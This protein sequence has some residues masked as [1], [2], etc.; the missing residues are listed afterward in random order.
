MYLHSNNLSKIDGNILNGLS[1]LTELHLS[2]NKLSYLDYKIFNGLSS[3]TEL[4]LHNNN[5]FSLEDYLFNGLTSLTKLELNYNKFNTSSY[6]SLKIAINSMTNKET[7]YINLQ[8]NLI[9]QSISDKQ[10]LCKNSSVCK[11]L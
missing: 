10:V 9:L 4:Y 2:W 3:L 6:N 1:K 5:L 11:I 7:C 8:G